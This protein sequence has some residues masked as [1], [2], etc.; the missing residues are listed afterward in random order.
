MAKPKLYGVPPSPFVRKVRVGLAEKGID[1][2]LEVVSPFGMDEAL[3]KKTPLGKIPFYEEG[4]FVIPDSSVI[5]GYLEQTHPEPALFPKDARERAR[6]L[7]L[8][9][10][11]DTRLSEGCGAVFFNRFVKTTLMKQ[12]S[13]EAAVKGALD[14]L[15]PPLL[16][17]LEEQ[18]GDQEYL[19]GGRFSVAD[20]AIAT[21]LRQ[22]ELGGESV[23]SSRWPRLDTWVKSIHARPSFKGCIEGEDQ[24]IKA[25]RG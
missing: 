17:W 19:V 25:M 2:D 9:E 7:F 3:K 16:S 13:D 24:M 5:L 21:Q 18:I 14:D 10:Y 15:L 22:L 11:G 20:I 1:Y 23:D 6:A 8:E 4:D 12:E